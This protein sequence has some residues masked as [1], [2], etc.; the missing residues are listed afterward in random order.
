MQ[1]DKE[2]FETLKQDKNENEEFD[3]SLKLLAKSSFVVFIGIFLSKALTYLYKIKIARMQVEGVTDFGPLIYGRFSL[4]LMILGWFIVFSSFGLVDGM[5]RYISIYRAKNEFNKI[6]HVI[7]TVMIFLFVSSLIFSLTLFLSSE[8]IAVTLF[9][10]PGLVIYLKF[11]SFLI[12]FSVFASIFLSILQAFEKINL[13]SAIRNILDNIVKLVAIFV[14]MF[15]GL[16]S[17]AVIFSYILGTLSMLLASYYFCKYKLPG[18]FEKYTLD[19][20]EKSRITKDL[21]SYS[22]PLVFSSILLIAFTE[23]D[24][25][26]IGYFIDVKNVGIYNSATPIAALLGIVPSLLIPLF[27]PLITKEFAKGNKEV[28]KQI[29]KQLGKWI[30]IINLPFLIL[31]ILFPGAIINIL[32]GSQYIGSK[33]IIFNHQFIASE[34]ALRFLAIGVFFYSLFILSENLLSMAGKSKIVLFDI[35]ATSVFNV[36]L[37]AFL[38]SKYGIAGA[39][40]AT[41]LSYIIWSILSMFQARH[42]VSIIPLRRK[43]LLIIL[44][45]I[46]PTFFLIFIKQFILLNKITLILQGSLFLLIYILLIFLT[47]CLDKNDIMVIKA[48]KKKISDNSLIRKK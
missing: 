28:I 13:Y 30:F 10:D 19:S 5:V 32:F 22:W 37:N 23:I 16:M 39:A 6:R 41:M 31:M 27:F 21:F 25:L 34:L 38:I 47:G 15:I 29:T 1:K 8:F 17:G 35:I 44:I 11:F 3:N 7:K 42:Y 12:I 48:I 33:L 18:V 4:S 2:S 43:M 36:I 46:I 9:K 20:G 45:A 14:L 40:F 26:M 24:S